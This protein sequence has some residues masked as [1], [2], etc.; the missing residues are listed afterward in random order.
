MDTVTAPTTARKFVSQRRATRWHPDPCE[1]EPS[2]I[3]WKENP[4][5]EQICINTVAIALAGLV[6]DGR[7]SQA[8]ADHELWLYMVR[9]EETPFSPDFQPLW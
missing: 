8:A 4:T 1:C 9:L 7:L 2:F 3:R 5:R 6:A